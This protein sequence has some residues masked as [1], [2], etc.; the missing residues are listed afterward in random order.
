MRS[1]PQGGINFV[2]NF[3]YF[4]PL[5]SMFK[6]LLSIYVSFLAVVS[7]A[8]SPPEE[9]SPLEAVEDTN[10]IISELTSR[11]GENSKIILSWIVSSS[12]PQFFAIERSENGKAYEVVSILNNLSRQNI[13]QWADEAPKKG[14]NLYRIRYGFKPG[15]SLYSNTILVSVAGYDAFKFYPNP[16][17]H[18]LI[19]RS[20][21]PLDVMITDGNGRLRISHSKVHGLYT[22]N[23]SS[24]EKG[25]YLIRFI[26]KLTNVMSQ[27]KLIKN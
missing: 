1:F 7:Y 24:L 14:R 22:I 15:D 13:Y 21:A 23:V 4:Y 19:V 25:V 2:E 12:L 6:I 11:I 9:S 8:Q 10:R 27:E 16:V 3:F 20:D 5:D 26:N 18:I 17:D